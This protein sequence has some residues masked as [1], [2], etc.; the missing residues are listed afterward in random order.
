[1]WC[2]R[3]SLLPH[4]EHE[5]V[6]HL[7]DIHCPRLRHLRDSIRDVARGVRAS[8]VG[9][10]ELVKLVLVGVRGRREQLGCVDVCLGTNGMTAF[11][12]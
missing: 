9:D 10:T 6:Q 2:A 1:M 11:L 3:S 4:E 5:Q 8:E 12:L 7:L